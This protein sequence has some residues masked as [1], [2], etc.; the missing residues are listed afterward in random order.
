MYNYKLNGLNKTYEINYSEEKITITNLVKIFKDT[1]KCNKNIFVYLKDS[2][3]IQNYNNVITY[4]DD[5][6]ILQQSY[7]CIKTIDLQLYINK[8]DNFNIDKEKY[9]AMTNLIL[10][11]ANI[12]KIIL[13]SYD[14]YKIYCDSNGSFID[15][16]S[17]F[18]FDFNNHSA[19]YDLSPYHLAILGKKFK[20]LKKLTKV[21]DIN[22]KK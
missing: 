2:E 21:L 8:F 9:N 17:K 5:I 10:N 16:L 15:F 22:C 3:N 1:Y 4:L 18:G 7:N 11:G 6:F 12:N 13:S 20:I 14:L 19:N